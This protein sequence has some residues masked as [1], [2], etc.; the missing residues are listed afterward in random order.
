MR[1]PPIP[2]NFLEIIKAR[3]PDWFKNLQKPEVINF[4]R[5]CNNGY[6]HWHKLRYFKHLPEGMDLND[7]WAVIALSRFQQFQSLPIQFMDSSMS[8]WTPP[9]QLEWLHKIDKQ[10]GGKIGTNAFYAISDENGEIFIQFI[11]GR[12]D[13]FK[14]A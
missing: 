8:F 6:V 3:G 1:I 12:S 2:P 10:A 14:F 4:V 11:N 5:R 9:Q 13:C 7:C